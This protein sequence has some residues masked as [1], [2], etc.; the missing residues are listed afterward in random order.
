VEGNGKASGKWNRASAVAV[1]PIPGR[2]QAATLFIDPVIENLLDASQRG[3][4][5][6]IADDFAA[7][8][9]DVVDVSL[10][11][12]GRRVGDCKSLQE[13]TEVSHQLFAGRRSFLLPIQERGQPSSPRQ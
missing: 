13:G 2:R 11:G 4:F 9:P 8:R 6:E 10:N 1:L 5:I 12:F 3:I 7:Q